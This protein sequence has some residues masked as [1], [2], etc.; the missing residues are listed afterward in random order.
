VTSTIRFALLIAAGV[1]AVIG[2]I[3]LFSDV[4]IPTDNVIVDSA[5]CGTAI[6][7]LDHESGT[8]T[9]EW[10]TACA[11]AVTTRSGAAYAAPFLFCEG[12]VRRQ[13]HKTRLLEN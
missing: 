6:S 4:T 1:L 3:T 11:D 2:T 13:N 5:E 12:S 7:P 10:E 8:S 9:P